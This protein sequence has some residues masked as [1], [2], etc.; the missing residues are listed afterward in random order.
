M[1]KHTVK[2]INKAI[3]ADFFGMAAEMAFWFLLALF[4]FL[5]FLTA[6]FAWLGKQSMID[7]IINFLTS[8]V[9]S[10]VARLILTAINEAMIF[11]QGG[12]IA[13]FGFCI[14]IWL[15]SNA[16]FV[17]MKGLNR[18]YEI[19]ETRNFLLTRTLAILMVFG[20][21]FILFLS[22]NLIIL[23]KV[24]L[25]LIINFTP[26]SAPFINFILIAR[27][28]VTFLA[29]FVM[30]F[31]NYYILPAVVGHEKIKRK[32]AIPGAFTFCILWLLG[33]GTFSLY[34]SN[35]NTY[36]RVY[37]T[38]GAF[39]ILMVWLYYTSL[40]ILLGGE[41]SSHMYK[42]LIKSEEN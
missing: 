32:C 31:I 38:I 1:K 33:S 7:P 12:L 39:A 15:S 34:L 35:L 24:I 11:K 25:E 36:N 28:P 3:D 13:I 30:A 27:W 17:I 4:P 37:G 22:V 23:G 14:T 40:I 8:I 5:L 6:F 42:R 9:P 41:V 2:F 26:L 18:T 20:N 16:V 21:A 10:E 19:E 29:L